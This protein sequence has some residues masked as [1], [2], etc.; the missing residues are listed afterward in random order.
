[1]RE[2]PL[3]DVPTSMGVAGEVMSIFLSRSYSDE[4]T[5]VQYPNPSAVVSEDGQRRGHDDHR[6]PSPL[7]P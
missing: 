4:S 3:I 7:S 2:I 5:L 1:M 6:G